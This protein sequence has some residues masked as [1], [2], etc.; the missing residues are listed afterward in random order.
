VPCRSHGNPQHL[1]PAFAGN[2]ANGFFKFSFPLLNVHARRL[3]HTSRRQDLARE[4]VGSDFR[5]SW[6]HI[7]LF[8]INVVV[9]LVSF[10][11]CS[12]YLVPTT[13]RA[14]DFAVSF[15]FGPVEFS[16]RGR[17]KALFPNV[18]VSF[19]H[20]RLACKLEIIRLR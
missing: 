12:I 11:R 6:I 16:P 7:Y 8:I 20:L 15:N 3:P 4:L 19:S 9:D 18:V 1:P 13:T 17:S 2:L 10:H 5:P 14:P